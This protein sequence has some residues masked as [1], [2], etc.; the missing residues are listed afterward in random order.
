[1]SNH[2]VIGRL[3]DTVEFCLGSFG[4]LK[5][6]GK[7]AFIMLLWVCIYNNFFEKKVTVQLLLT[8]KYLLQ[9]QVYMWHFRVKIEYYS[10]HQLLR[11]MHS[12][13]GNL[14]IF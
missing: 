10:I 5:L 2:F 9:T 7:Q 1:M 3:N 12:K 8:L 13:F 4:T 6:T 11:R 14:S